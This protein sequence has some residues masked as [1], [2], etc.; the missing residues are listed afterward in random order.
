MEDIQ[1][2]TATLQALVLVVS[3]PRPA[4]EDRLEKRCEITQGLL[5][6]SDTALRDINLGSAEVQT[7]P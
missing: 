5:V 2:V 3:L 1:E 6:D 7:H 4:C